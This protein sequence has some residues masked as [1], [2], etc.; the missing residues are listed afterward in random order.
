[1]ADLSAASSPTGKISADYVN[2]QKQVQD[3]ITKYG[4]TTAEQIPVYLRSMMEIDSSGALQLKAFSTNLERSRANKWV[5]GQ[6]AEGATANTQ[7]YS[8][9]EISSILVNGSAEENITSDNL[10]NFFNNEKSKND[11][12]TN[13]KITEFLKASQTMSRN[14]QDPNSQKMT[15]GLLTTLANSGPG[16]KAGLEEMA[17]SYNESIEAAYETQA[18]RDLHRVDTT[19]MNAEQI[20]KALYSK[21]VNSEAKVRSA[22]KGALQNNKKL[23]F[24]G[25]ASAHLGGI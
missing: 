15:Q 5:S 13:R 24:T 20:Q 4:Y 18:D 12:A 8:A 21:Y 6:I 2:A 16:G 22:F 7:M 19:L 14:Y 17:R 25:T 1:M 9:E 23:T 11:S 10:K 3:M